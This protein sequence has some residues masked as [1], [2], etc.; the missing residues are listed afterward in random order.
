MKSDDMRKL[1]TRGEL[2]NVPDGTEERPDEHVEPDHEYNGEFRFCN[3]APTK[4]KRM[5]EVEID[6]VERETIEL[7][8]HYHAM[9]AG[10]RP[11]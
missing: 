3:V 8:L 4:L 7:G 2:D 11:N 1:L 9:K 5:L 10:G 6:V